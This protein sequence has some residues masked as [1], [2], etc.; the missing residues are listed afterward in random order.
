MFGNQRL[1]TDAARGGVAA[2]RFPARPQVLNLDAVFGRPVERHSG[3]IFVVQRDAETRT[4]FPQLLFVELLLLVGD[5][6]AFARLAQPITLDGACKNDGRS[7]PVLAGRLVRRVDLARIMAA[8]TQTPQGFIRQWLDQLQQ[9]LVI[10]EKV[11]AYV[12]TGRDHQLLVFT[13]DQFAHALDE[14]PFRV[15]FENRIPLAAP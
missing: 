8:E 1:G 6:F 3:A 7:A 5:V 14:Q 11:L 13:I 15:A 2:K 10:S 12:R 9:T 4:E